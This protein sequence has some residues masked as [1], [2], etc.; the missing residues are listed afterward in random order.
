M[1]RRVLT[2]VGGFVKIGVLGL[3]VERS[4]GIR[5]WGQGHKNELLFSVLIVEFSSSILLLRIGQEIVAEADVEIKTELAMPS[6]KAQ[7]AEHTGLWRQV[8]GFQTRLCHLTGYTPW[9]SDFTD[10][11]FFFSS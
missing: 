3:A 8:P 1:L 6:V 4:Q 5:Q 10:L 2:G 9:A 7:G 11:C